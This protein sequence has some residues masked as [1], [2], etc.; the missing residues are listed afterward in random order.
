MGKSHSWRAVEA[1]GGHLAGDLGVNEPCAILAPFQ[2]LSETLNWVEKLEGARLPIWRRDV[3]RKFAR[4]RR[5]K[6]WRKFD[7]AP[8]K[9]WSHV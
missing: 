5:V 7:L 9:E 2:R 6:E 1:S 3:F 8:N 4:F